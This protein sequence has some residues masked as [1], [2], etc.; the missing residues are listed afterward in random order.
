MDFTMK[1][2]RSEYLQL[3]RVNAIL[4]AENE[5]LKKELEALKN[6]ALKETTQTTETKK[7]GANK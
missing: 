3:K 5:S 4:A 1:I 6:K 2:S 7:K